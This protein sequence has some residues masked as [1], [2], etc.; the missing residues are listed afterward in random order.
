M[1]ADL[2]LPRGGLSA[3]VTRHGSRFAEQTRLRETDDLK[4]GVRARTLRRVPVFTSRSSFAERDNKE[5][6][7]DGR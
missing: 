6:I 2:R 7:A 3:N 1:L 4:E 5:D